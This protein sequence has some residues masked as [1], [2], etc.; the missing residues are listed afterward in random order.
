V[1]YRKGKCLERKDG[2][3]M[4]GERREETGNAQESKL[5]ELRLRPGCLCGDGPLGSCS[6]EKLVPNRRKTNLNSCCL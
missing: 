6:K 4:R 5:T 1:R 3:R 2:G